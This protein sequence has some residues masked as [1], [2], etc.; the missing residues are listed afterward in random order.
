MSTLAQRFE[1]K[2]LAEPTSGCWL[3]EG[4]CHSNAGYGLIKVQG[5]FVGAHRVSYELYRGPI[6]DGLVIDHLCRNRACVNPA[7][8]ETV[9]IAENVR[10]GDNSNRLKTHCKRGHEFTTYNTLILSTG[11]RACRQ[12][13]RLRMIAFKETHAHGQ[14]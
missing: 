7:H 4:A 11:S 2:Y 14:S 1:A 3:W 8:L 13:A 9:S 5:K 10:R 6:P 12:C